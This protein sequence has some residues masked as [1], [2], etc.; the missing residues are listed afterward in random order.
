[1]NSIVTIPNVMAVKTEQLQRL[2]SLVCKC[3]KAALFVAIGR[4]DVIVDDDSELSGKRESFLE[5]SCR[6]FAWRATETSVCKLLY[7]FLSLRYR[8]LI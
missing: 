6:K 7:V 3:L 5:D 2:A 8:K 4:Y 1:M